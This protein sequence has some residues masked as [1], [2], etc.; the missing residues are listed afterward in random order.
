MRRLY[1]CAGRIPEPDPLRAAQFS[2]LAPVYALRLQLIG[3]CG[4]G[5]ENSCVQGIRLNAILNHK[6]KEI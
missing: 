3:G 5:Q 1:K 2:I 6:Q 4:H